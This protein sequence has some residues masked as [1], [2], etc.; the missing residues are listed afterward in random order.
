MVG[1]LYTIVECRIPITF[2]LCICQRNTPRFPVTHC[3]SFLGH[4]A[5]YLILWAIQSS[6]FY[7]FQPFPLLSRLFLP[8]QMPYDLGPLF[9]LT[10]EWPAYKKLRCVWCRRIVPLY[11]AACIRLSCTI[12]LTVS[13]YNWRLMTTKCA[14]SSQMMVALRSA[15]SFINASSP[16]H[17]PGPD[18]RPHTPQINVMKRFIVRSAVKDCHRV[19]LVSRHCW[20]N[21]LK[22]VKVQK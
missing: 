7:H 11:I 8:I 16:T 1:Q 21:S 4:Q 19:L 12:T 10:L 20:W 15:S 13:A 17:F 18:N 2:G 5:T 9:P 22:Q 6:C 3:F 14:T